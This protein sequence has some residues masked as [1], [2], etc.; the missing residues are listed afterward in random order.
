MQHNI[1]TKHFCSLNCII[2]ISTLHLS[3][4]RLKPF[5]RIESRHFRAKNAKYTLDPLQPFYNKIMQNS[6]STSY[7][8]S[9]YSFNDAF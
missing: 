9:N 6:C 5:V 7:C 1:M 2:K 4:V 8:L 3:S